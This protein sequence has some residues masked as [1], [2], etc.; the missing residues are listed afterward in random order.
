MKTKRLSIRISETL[1]KFLREY[2]ILKFNGNISEA[3]CYILNSFRIEKNRE[4]QELIIDLILQ[5]E[6]LKNQLSP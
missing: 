2:A 4:I 5:V 1:Y 6:E 3:V